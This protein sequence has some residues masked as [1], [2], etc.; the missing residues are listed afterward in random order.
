[1]VNLLYGRIFF[2]FHGPLHTYKHTYIIWYAFE[3]TLSPSD[4]A[5]DDGGGGGR[6]LK[7]YGRHHTDHQ[8]GHRVRK[9]ITL[10]KCFT[11]RFS[12]KQMQEKDVE[13]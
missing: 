6:A 13:K 12:W 1:M 5:D 2:R 11:R 3:L 9:Y 4:H 10:F 8:S 7:Q